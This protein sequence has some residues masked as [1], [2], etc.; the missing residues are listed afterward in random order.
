MQ[1]K[2][3]DTPR[4]GKQLVSDLVTVLSFIGIA[5]AMLLTV[6]DVGLRL[7]STIIEVFTNIR[8]R[9]G[10]IGVVDLMQLAIMVA[11]PLGIG[12]NFLNNR[13]IRVDIALDFLG[14]RFCC[15]SRSLTAMTGIAV[16]GIC[17]WSASKELNGQF[18]FP[19]SS[20]TL[21]LPLT[22]YWMPLIAGLTISLVVCISSFLYPLFERKPNGGKH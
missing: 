7:S 17:L 1:T 8:P 18:V 21:S 16:L 4:S 12:V 11:V 9:W 10:I 20:A 13:H 2:H 19:S 22:W 5:L 14:K 6:V 15:F 3:N